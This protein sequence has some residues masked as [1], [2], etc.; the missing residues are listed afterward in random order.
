[1]PS[2]VVYKYVICITLIQRYTSGKFIYNFMHTAVKVNFSDEM[3]RIH[4][5]NQSKNPT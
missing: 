1:M 2:N 3:K 5:S 4:Q